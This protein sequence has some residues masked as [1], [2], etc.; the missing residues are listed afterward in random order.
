MISKECRFSDFV[1]AIRDKDYFEVVHLADQEATA[2][3][4]LL[5]RS[6]VDT[7]LG[8]AAAGIRRADQAPHRLHALRSQPARQECRR[9]GGPCGRQ[10]GTAP[11]PGSVTIP[12]A[13]HGSPK[14]NVLT[15]RS[16]VRRQRRCADGIRDRPPHREPARIVQR[17]RR[18]GP[19][20]RGELVN[21][22]CCPR[23][24]ARRDLPLRKDGDRQEA[25]PVPGVRSTVQPRPPA[26]WEPRSGRPVPPAENRC[27]STCAGGAWSASAA[28]SIRAAA[29]LK[30][31]GQAHLNH[32]HLLPL[33]K[34]S[35]REPPDGPR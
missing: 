21:G 17:P 6:R 29:F 14:L 4:R 22:V 27:T 11:A 34:P 9:C 32:A 26:V 30:L 13:T 7:G 28:P 5:L 35:Q 12:P 10:P 16:S 18:T 31:E 19:E 24:Q 23:C 2:A 20:R 25:I 33:G 1:G 8:S 3:E 15:S